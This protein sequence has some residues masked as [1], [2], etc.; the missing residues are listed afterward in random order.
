MLN[1]YYL[2][3]GDEQDGNENVNTATTL[4]YVITD[5]TDD[6]EDEETAEMKD[7]TECT[8]IM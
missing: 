5:E 3:D 8:C 6:G 2:H 7:T 1:R 4:V